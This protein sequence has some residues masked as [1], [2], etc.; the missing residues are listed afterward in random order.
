MCE[1]AYKLTWN[2][3]NVMDCCRNQDEEETRQKFSEVDTNHDGLLSWPE[4]AEKVFGYSEEELL[5]FTQ[6]SH[7]EMQTFN[8]VIIWPHHYK[9]VQPVATDL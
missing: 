4:Y 5:K 3:E 7:P 6:D 2:V 1:V 9:H 8:R